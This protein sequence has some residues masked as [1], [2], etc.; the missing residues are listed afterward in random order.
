MLSPELILV[1][2]QSARMWFFV[3]PAVGCHYFP[4]YLRSPSQPK[5]VTVLRPVPSYTACWQAHRC[6]QLAH[7]CYA[8]FSRWKSIPQPNDR[9]FNA[10][11]L[12]RWRNY[13]ISLVLP[14]SVSIRVCLSVCLSFGVWSIILKGWKWKRYDGTWIRFG[15]VVEVGWGCEGKGKGKTQKH[16]FRPA[17]RYMVIILNPFAMWRYSVIGGQDEA[18][19]WRC[20]RGG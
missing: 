6:E 17:R 1:Y 18:L 5:N 20:C 12:K 19:W 2:R 10:S 15:V 7:S 8:A 9:K 3:I 11:P 4:P 14:V 13:V 16:A